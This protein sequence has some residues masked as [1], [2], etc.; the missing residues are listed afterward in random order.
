MASARA[1]D[2]R[3]R[4]VDTAYQ[5]F[6]RNGIQ[7]VG[8][9][10]ILEEAGVAKATLYKHF[11]SKEDLVVAAL[12]RHEEVWTQGWLEREVER[13]GGSPGER[14]LAVFDA[15]DRW[16]HREDFEGC[17]F[18][19]TLLESHDRRSG[20]GRGGSQAASPISARSWQVSRS[21]PASAIPVGSRIS[22]KC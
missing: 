13:R 6:Q 12:E 2:P 18:L 10:R 21:R 3:E 7:A 4:L 11:P 22:G 15:F 5:L 1:S 17:L 16:F 19:G 14:L 8:I 20:V 9:N